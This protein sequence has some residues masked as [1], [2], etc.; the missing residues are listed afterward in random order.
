M[1]KV[2]LE[3]VVALA[4]AVGFENPAQKDPTRICSLMWLTDGLAG[5]N[6]LYPYV[7]GLQYQIRE[8]KCT[9]VSDSGS[10]SVLPQV[11]SVLVTLGDI[12]QVK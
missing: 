11:D 7:V 9:M 3:I 4:G 10:V 1:E 5:N 12:A 8:Q 2:G 6:K